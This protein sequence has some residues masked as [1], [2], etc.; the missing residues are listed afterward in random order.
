MSARRSRLQLAARALC[1][2]VAGAQFGFMK[3]RIIAQFNELVRALGGTPQ[4]AACGCTEA[5][6]C[7][8]GCYWV[9]PERCSKCEEG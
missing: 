1:D 6:A 9:A 3:P 7:R 8:G 4:C 5:R 2:S